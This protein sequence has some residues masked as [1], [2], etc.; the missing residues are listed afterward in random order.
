MH[1]AVRPVGDMAGV[2]IEAKASFSLLP[3]RI[4][5]CGTADPFP[6]SIRPQLPLSH[7]SAVGLPW[8]LGGAELLGFLA[9]DG[10]RG[11]H[12]LVCCAQTP[13]HAGQTVFC[14]CPCPLRV[15]ASPRYGTEGT[16]KANLIGPLTRVRARVDLR[17]SGHCPNRNPRHVT[18]PADDLSTRPGRG[19]PHCDK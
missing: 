18:S 11:S 17:A 7:V 19:S 9:P 15:P 1:S 14:L 2:C 5:P 4:A 8:R 13:E 12:L 3:G 16:T 6:C 10:F